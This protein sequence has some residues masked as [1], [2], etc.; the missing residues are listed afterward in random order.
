MGEG[1]PVYTHVKKLRTRTDVINDI[2][3]ERDRQN[4]K[5][6][7]QHHDYNTWLTILVEEVGEVSQAIQ[8]NRRWG[9][10]GDKQNL[11]EEL[12]QVSAVA[13][14]VA[15]QVLKDEH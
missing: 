13:A 14:A 15:E 8:A 1:L 5:W 2:N 11:Y 7:E 3:C 4:Y 6:G 10:D 12:I 9:K